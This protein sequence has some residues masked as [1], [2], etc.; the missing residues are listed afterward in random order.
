[1]PGVGGVRTDQGS[2]GIKAASRRRV[3]AARGGGPGLA[4]VARPAPRM[5]DVPAR[6]RSRAT[7]GHGGAGALDVPADD[8]SL[9]PC[10]SG[11]DAL[12]GRRHG[13]GHAAAVVGDRLHGWLQGEGSGS[14][15]ADVP[16]G[17]GGGDEGNRTPNPRL[18]KAVLC[19]LSYVPGLSTGYGTAPV[20]GRGV[21]ERGG[22]R[23]GSI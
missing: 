14:G 22:A 3:R 19:Q 2:A 1:M 10:P 23:H 18:A 4:A 17:E 16:A 6:E 13:P 8:G 20:E 11:A 21:V 7:D 15:R 5:R 12:G 9:R